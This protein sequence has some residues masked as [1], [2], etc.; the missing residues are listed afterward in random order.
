MKVNLEAG[1]LKLDLNLTAFGLREVEDV[2]V[3]QSEDSFPTE[4]DAPPVRICIDISGKWAPVSGQAP[5]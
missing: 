1:H 4:L 3:W 2:R 5:E